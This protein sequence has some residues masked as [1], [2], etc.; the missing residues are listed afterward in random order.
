M[1]LDKVIRFH[2]LKPTDEIV[3]FYRQAHLYIQSSLH[4]SQGVVVCEA[5]AAGV[6]TVGTAVGLVAELAPEAAWAVPPGDAEGLASGIFALLQDNAQRQRMGRAA[7]AL[8]RAH[9]AD[10]TAAQFE[11]IYAKY[12][13][14]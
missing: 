9:D 11:A 10:W 2:G 13:T 14:L 6:P 1:G 8:A 3:P 7:Q 12:D 5:A 4:E